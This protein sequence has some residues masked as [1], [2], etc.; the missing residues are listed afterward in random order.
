[1]AKK[2]KAAKAAIKA[3]K[4]GKL[5]KKVGGVKLDK[6]VRKSAE[7]VIARVRG[8]EGQRMVAAGLAMAASA[9]A[10]RAGAPRPAAPVPPEPP[11]PPVPPIPP[12]P[13]VPPVPPTAPPD[14]MGRAQIDPQEIADAFGKAATAFFDGLFGRRR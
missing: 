14:G 11:V 8:P 3:A 10:A 12:V 6:A 2:D 9:M 1:M 13:P 4:T 7:K 5:P